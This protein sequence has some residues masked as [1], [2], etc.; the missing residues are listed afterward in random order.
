MC[1]GRISSFEGRA[2]SRNRTTRAFKRFTSDE[3]KPASSAT[4]G[5]DSATFRFNISAEPLITASGFRISCAS[6]AESCPSA[7]RRSARRASAS[8]RRSSRFVSSSFS[9][10]FSSRS[11]WRRFSIA[12]RLTNIAAIKKNRTRIV[13]ML[14]PA[15]SKSPSCSASI[16]SER[17]ASDATA[18][19]ASVAM[20]PKKTAALTTG[21]KK[22]G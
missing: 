18:V 1:S 7:A 12:K 20:G 11:T 13:S 4:S 16:K 17:Y 9:E 10:R 6:P 3:I 2:K 14:A 5:W 21:R 19:H 22:M 8:A 15:E